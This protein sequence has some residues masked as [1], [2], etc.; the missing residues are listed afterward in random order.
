MNSD[1]GKLHALVVKLWTNRSQNKVNV[2]E[3][4]YI[5]LEQKKLTKEDIPPHHTYG[6]IFKKE[7]A[8]ASVTERQ[9]ISELSFKDNEERISTIGEY[10]GVHHA[11]T[12]AQLLMNI[13]SVI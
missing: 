4:E 7:K 12:D 13:P 5:L 1:D 8:K 3:I 11:Y 6:S 2:V 9:S 10:Y